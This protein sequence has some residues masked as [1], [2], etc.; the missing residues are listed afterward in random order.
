MQKIAVQLSNTTFKHFKSI[1]GGSI[2]NLVEWYDWYAYSVFSLY[3]ASSFFPEENET[4]QLLNTA[5]IFA[6]GFLLRPVGGWLMGAYADRNGR[7]AGLT[8]SVLLMSAGSLMITLVPNYNHIGIAAPIILVLARMLQGLSIGGEYGTAATYL[9]EIAPPNRRGLYSSFQYVTTTMGQ[10]TALSVLMILER[11][12][13]TPEQLASWGWRI[14]FAIGA[15]LALSAI[16]LRRNLTETESFSNE[17]AAKSQ[18]GTWQELKKHKK[19]IFT[20]VG[21]TIGLTVSYY[22]FST[23][24]QKF[25]VNTAGFSK[26]DST[27][28][29]TL[30]LLAFMLVQPLAGMLGDFIG[31]KRLMVIY[32]VLG[33]VTTVPI[34]TMLGNTHQAWLAALLIIIALCI[35]SLNTSIS[36]IVKAE[37]FPVNVRSLGVSFPY[38]FTVALF[39]GTA[40]YL[41]LLFKNAGHATW[42]YWYLTVCIGISLWV[43][44]RMLDMQKHSKMDMK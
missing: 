16:Y 25:L 24:V 11:W 6:I 42:F 29:T 43:S 21:F 44:I 28:I 26:R 27:L 39:G 17:T 40:E 35:L 8:L 13:L 31:R 22:T 2:G 7:K 9:S 41:A 12:L 14:P 38:A 15:L 23:Y 4:A 3:F 10:L 33:L 32:G 5:G 30:S 34:L 20:I 36:A 18:R 37:L 19:E 1:I